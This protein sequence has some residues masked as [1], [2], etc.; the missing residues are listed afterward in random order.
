[1]GSRKWFKICVADNYL[2]LCPCVV[3]HFIYYAIIISSSQLL[4]VYSPM[5]LHLYPF[6]LPTFNHFPRISHCTVV[7]NKLCAFL[8]DRNRPGLLLYHRFIVKDYVLVERE[9]A[10]AYSPH[11]W[12]CYVV[13]AK[14]DVSYT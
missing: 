11:N 5:F 7:I 8:V 4:A 3:I 13:D 1:M 9:L 6:F 10:S 2:A 12:Y 14:A